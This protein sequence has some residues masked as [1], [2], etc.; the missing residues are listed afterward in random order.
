MIKQEYLFS[1]GLI[2]IAVRSNEL[3]RLKYECKKNQSMYV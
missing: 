1:F 3:L 2:E